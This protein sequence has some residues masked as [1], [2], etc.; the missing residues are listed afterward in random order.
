MDEYRHYSEKPTLIWVSVIMILSALS[1]VT[2]VLA[3]T[4]MALSLALFAIG[5]TFA[6]IGITIFIIAVVYP[7]IIDKISKPRKYEDD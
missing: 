7:A 1:L 2:A 6:S 4:A 5:V 3:N